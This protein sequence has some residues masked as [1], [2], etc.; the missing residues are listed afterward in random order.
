[1]ATKKTKIFTT[2]DKEGNVIKT[3][4]EDKVKKKYNIPVEYLNLGMYFVIP[5][6]TGFFIGLWLDKRF[7]RKGFFTIL[8]MSIGVIASFY[9]LIKLYKQDESAH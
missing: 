3:E 2:V 1:M 4:V 7:D 5:I 6:L 8:L 9:N